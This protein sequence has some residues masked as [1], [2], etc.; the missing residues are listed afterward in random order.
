MSQTLV[1][2]IWKHRFI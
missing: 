2:S 1:D